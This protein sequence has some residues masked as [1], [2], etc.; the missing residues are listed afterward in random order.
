M[1]SVLTQKEIVKVLEY[2]ELRDI[3]WGNIFILALFY[4][5]LSKVIM[6][7]IINA[8][9]FGQSGN[10]NST[11]LL[12]HKKGIVTSAS[13]IA[14]SIN[15]EEA[16]GISRENPGLGIGVHLC[17]DGPFNIGKSYLSI[18]SKDTGQF[19]SKQGITQ[20][21]KKFSVDESEIFAEYCLQIE[22]VLDSNVRISH[23]DHHHH[24]HLYFPALKMMIKAARKY[25]IRYIRSQRIFLHKNGNYLN[26]LYRNMHQVYLKSRIKTLDGYFEPAIKEHSDIE[27]NYERFSKL[28]CYKNK[29]IEIMLHPVEENDP[30]TLFF[31]S[32]KAVNLLNTTK[33][34]NYNDLD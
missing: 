22:K 1:L 4:L 3:V 13:L 26:Y 23:L 14:N 25:K 7:L 24:L 19:H 15:F 29:V 12:L 28:V 21:L 6:S 2:A 17:L 11:I 18:I 33:L 34:L 10:V 31:T 9:D 32:D 8:D 30:E 5:Q 20:K 27:S 16:V